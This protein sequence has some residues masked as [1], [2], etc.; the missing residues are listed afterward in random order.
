MLL[1]CARAV[2]SRSEGI[3]PR[4]LS[5]CHQHQGITFRCN[6]RPLFLSTAAPSGSGP[7]RPKSAEELFRRYQ[8][9]PTLPR[10][11]PESKESRKTKL[12]KKFF[13]R[14][15][16]YLSNYEKIIKA[17]VPK[18]LIE[19]SKVLINGTKLIVTDMRE[20][21]W[22]YKVLSTTSDWQKAAGTLSRR[23]LELY[24]NLP[25]ELYRVA[26]VLV[27][28]AFPLMQN[29]AFPLALMYPKRLLSSHYWSDEL[30]TEVM[31]ETVQRRHKYY[32]SVFRS[33]QRG[34]EAHKGKPLHQ[35]C[36]VVLRKL[37]VEGKHPPE[38]DILALRPLFSRGGVFSLANV[39]SLHVR[40]LMRTNGR[41]SRWWWRYNLREFANLLME[42][43]RALVREDMEALSH[44]ELQ[45]NCGQRGVN[46]EGL[47]RSE[48][49]EYLG[50]WT[51]IS[52][53]LEAGSASLLLHLPVLLGYNHRTRHCD[54]SSV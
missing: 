29:V 1:S 49:L 7:G 32:R 34:L 16:E 40:H 22:A 18:K 28:S 50:A 30:K 26:P 36:F 2:S 21:A 12:R 13:F 52:G 19:A 25:A 43:D 4:L 8:E 23:Q 48:M 15:L 45:K 38:Q 9:H 33:L 31:S 42:I 20:F 35:S 44:E 51:R 17:I 53:Q 39:N 47:D 3:L 46:V 11:E 54:A 14:F 24:M 37:A 27:V 6:P 41:N 10:L 5:S